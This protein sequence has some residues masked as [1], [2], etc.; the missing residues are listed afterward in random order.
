[1]LGGLVPNAL[2]A[3]KDKDNNDVDATA[4]GGDGEQMHNDTATRPPLEL[5]TLSGHLGKLSPEQDRALTTFKA[6]LEKAGLYT[7]GK[8]DDNGAVVEKP[9]HDDATLLRFLRARRFDPAKAQKQFTDRCTW[10]KKHN[11]DELYANFPTEEF[12]NA[13][14]FYPRW[15]GRRDRQGFPVYVYQLSALTSDIQ[16]EITAV[17]PERRYQRIIVLYEFMLRFVCPLCTISPHTSQPLSSTPANAPS[18]APT[19]ISSVTTIIDLQNTSLRQMWSLRSHLQ[20]ASVLA[21]A[22]YPE[23]LGPTVVL[24][25][26]PFFATVWGWIK[27]WFDEGTR[28]KIHVFGRDAS[29]PQ[30]DKDRSKN[31]EKEKGGWRASLSEIVDPDH[32]P[33]KYGGNLEWEFFDAPA[34]DDEM[35]RSLREGGGDGSMPHGP[36]IFDVDVNGKGRIVRPKEY[37]APAGSEGAGAGAADGAVGVQGS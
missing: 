10:E 29:A 26:P 33:K 35:A 20:E 24:N 30:A 3:D 34:L 27:G 14:R 22:N 8:A 25:A 32:L 4:A 37:I 18:Q 19:A 13:R 1:M 21:N 6:N 31:K 5:P 11:V 9:S 16:S 2:S 15:T 36:W 17:S 23:T 28:G 7:P 12:E